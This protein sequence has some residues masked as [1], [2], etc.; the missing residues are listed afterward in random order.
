MVS[1]GLRSPSF[2][3]KQDESMDHH[4]DEDNEDEDDDDEA[5]V[6]VLTIRAEDSL[7]GWSSSTRT[8]PE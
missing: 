1:S 2:G 3:W 7:V 6:M 4:W 5:D 8:M